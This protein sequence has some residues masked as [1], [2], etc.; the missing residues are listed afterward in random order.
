MN[1]NAN[2][3]KSMYVDKIS[4]GVHQ[5]PPAKLSSVTEDGAPVNYA[6]FCK[7][8]CVFRNTIHFTCI[9]HSAVVPVTQ[10]D[11]TC[12]VAKK[13]MS[14]YT[15]CLT[16]SVKFRK[17]TRRIYGQNPEK[18]HGIRWMSNLRAAVQLNANFVAVERSIRDEDFGCPELVEK[19]ILILD[20]QWDVLPSVR[21]CPDCGC[22]F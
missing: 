1:T 16:W 17:Y 2:V 20:E 19:M 8:Q 5:Q 3:F 12:S 9:A 14:S 18:L 15:Q 6:S 22:R 4:L 10:L 13:F 7:A 21:A 11:K